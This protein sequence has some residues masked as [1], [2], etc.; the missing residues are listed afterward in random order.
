MMVLEGKGTN[1]WINVLGWETAAGL[2]RHKGGLNLGGRRL[3][4]AL[5]GPHQWGCLARA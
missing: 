4:K 3:T 2:Q 5:L 1:V